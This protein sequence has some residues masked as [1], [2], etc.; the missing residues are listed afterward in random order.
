MPFSAIRPSDQSRDAASEENACE[1]AVRPPPRIDRV[2]AT[3]QR[4]PNLRFRRGHEEFI[5]E[6]PCLA[7]GR[8]AP[9]ECAHVRTG[10]DGGVS[11]KPSS[12]Y[13]VPL[14]AACHRTG[15]GAQHTVGELAFWSRLRIDPLNVALKLWT[16]S[17]DIQAGER[18]VFRAQQQINLAMQETPA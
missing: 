1:A 8:P 5:G 11:L 18:V 2:V 17:G 3:H 14:C 9:S 4:K 16:V 15:H 12:R 10:T 7:C 13:T 6:L